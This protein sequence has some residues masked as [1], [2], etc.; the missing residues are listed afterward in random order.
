MKQ[1]WPIG[2]DRGWDYLSL[3]TVSGRLYIGRSDRVIVLDTHSGKQVGEIDGLS[4]VHGVALA[5][6]L[7]RGFISNGRAN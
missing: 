4:G 6:D 2:G 7:H 1:R 5:D 3:D